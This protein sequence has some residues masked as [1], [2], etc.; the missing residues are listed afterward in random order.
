MTPE[1]QLK[2]QAKQQ[3]LE[4]AA[5]EKLAKLAQEQ[6]RR[7]EQHP[8]ANPQQAALQQ[9]KDDKQLNVLA[10]KNYRDVFL[11][12]QV[13][14]AFQAQ[15]LTP[16]AEQSLRN[17]NKNLQ[18]KSWWKK[19]EG[20]QLTNALKAYSDTLTSLTTN[21]LGFG[22]ASPP[23]LP[24]PFSV[25]GLNALLATNAFDQNAAT[26]LIRDAALSDKLA[27][28]EQLAEA[29]NNFSSL[30]VTAADQG[31]QINP[32][33]LKEEVQAS[34]RSV[35]KG[36]ERYYARISASHAV[37]DAQ[38]ALLKSTADY[39]AKNRK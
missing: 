29:V 2:A 34:L 19:Q 14:N 4:Q 6:Q 33:K 36:M 3:Q 16:K 1:E 37:L 5:N 32:K 30:S 9:K 24:P 38:K 8:A 15:Q 26:Q 22:L 27:A 39:L 18:D 35:N 28:G 21:L 11:P 10:V 25:S 7:R 17:L 12:G 31:P 13:A 20:I 23:P